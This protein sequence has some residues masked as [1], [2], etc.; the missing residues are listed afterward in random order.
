[1][2]PSH[3]QVYLDSLTSEQLCLCADVGNAH[4]LRFVMKDGDEVS[5]IVRINCSSM[6]AVFV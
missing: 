2:W 3:V 6:I 1:M 4:I 5:D